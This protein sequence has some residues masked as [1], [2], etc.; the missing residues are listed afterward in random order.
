MPIRIGTLNLNG[1]RAAHRKGLQDLLKQAN[2]DIILF[3]EIRTNPAFDHRPFIDLEY[4][5]IINPA[6]KPGYSGTLIAHK[7]P[8]LYQ[9]PVFSWDN[10]T[11]C[12]EG[13]LIDCQLTENL[14]II[15]LYMP[16]GGEELRQKLKI[17]YLQALQNH[18][19]SQTGLTLVGGDI[20]IAAT[21]R[22][23]TNWKG[24]KGQPGC[25]LEER[26]LLQSWLTRNHWVDSYRVMHPVE[27]PEEYSWWSYRQ[28][29]AFAKNVGW[30]IDTIFLPKNFAHLC[31]NYGFISMPRC[32][33]HALYW[34]DLE[35]SL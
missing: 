2:C 13:R 33:D 16:S 32:S 31:T 9:P 30:R 19:L 27:A 7:L 22:D 1:L 17:E 25:T 29:H 26:D 3:Q 35:E 10:L 5:L 15:N 23:L 28:K 21:D 18:P 34:I 14:R 24:N 8:S 4:H 11:L 12:D 20:N 6:Q